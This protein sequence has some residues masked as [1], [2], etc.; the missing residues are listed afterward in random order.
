MNAC[1]YIVLAALVLLL[2]ACTGNV[3]QRETQALAGYMEYAQPPVERF[4]FWK[5]RDWELVGDYQLV[6]WPNRREAYLLTV[7][8]PCSEL[9]WAHAIG[10]SS[11]GQTVQRRLDTVNVGTQKCRIMEI[12]PID[13]AAM[14]RDRRRAGQAGSAAQSSGGT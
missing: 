1:R 7:D 6:V 5:L 12:R 3:R 4:R 13:Y 10:I 11:T 2:A 9:R 14:K 8:K